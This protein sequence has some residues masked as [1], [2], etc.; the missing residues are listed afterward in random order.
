[1][2]VKK[3]ELREKISTTLNK[4]IGAYSKF[5]TDT[6]TN[7]A[8]DYIQ[9]MMSGFAKITLAERK[10]HYGEREEYKHALNHVVECAA[11]RDCITLAESA[12]NRENKEDFEELGVWF[13]SYHFGVPI[14]SQ[15]YKEYLE[16]NDVWLVEHMSF[17]EWLKDHEY[18][19]EENG[20]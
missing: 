3:E 14:I 6:V 5:V 18:I 10:R 7:A 2:I 1:M 9:N 20:G 16:E 13:D 19:R 15:L 12:L 17:E 11:C 8:W 4:S